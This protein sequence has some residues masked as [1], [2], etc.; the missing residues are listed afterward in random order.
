MIRLLQDWGGWRRTKK[1]G[2][3]WGGS[4]DFENA[5]RL[6]RDPG[7]HSD[8]TYAEVSAVIAD[9]QGIYIFIEG[10]VAI[11]NRRRQQMMLARYEKMATW[12]RIADFLD[13][14]LDEM[15]LTHEAMI[16]AMRKEVK[17][18]I[19]EIIFDYAAQEYERDFAYA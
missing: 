9:G 19:D 7:T 2:Q 11:H 12:Q 14:H 6:A 8:P 15:E 5:V 16:R 1:Q 17:Q 3:G 10:L 4:V 13:W 18:Y